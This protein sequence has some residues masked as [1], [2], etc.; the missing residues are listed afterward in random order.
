MQQHLDSHR[1]PIGNSG[2][3]TTGSAPASGAAA[4]AAAAQAPTEPPAPLKAETGSTPGW[5]RGV[6]V[7]VLVAGM[8]ALAILA[9]VY[10]DT[11]RREI[12]AAAEAIHQCDLGAASTTLADTTPAQVQVQA[13]AQARARCHELRIQYTQRYGHEP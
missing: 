8:A 5:L 4:A 9:L 2:E 3:A 6:H 10:P 12:S 1:L 11:R 7:R 13:Q